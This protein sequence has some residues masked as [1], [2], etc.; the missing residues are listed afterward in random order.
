MSFFR[1]NSFYI[2]P[3]G[4]TV[5]HSSNS[6]QLILWMQIFYIFFNSRFI[7]FLFCFLIASFPTDNP[8]NIRSGHLKD[9]ISNNRTV[10]QENDDILFL[11]QCQ[12]ITKSVIRCVETSISV[13]L[14]DIIL[15]VCNVKEYV[16]LKLIDW[17]VLMSFLPKI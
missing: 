9:T 12:S 1:C 11:F 7:R 17:N 10:I 5:F 16:E 3:L 2:V 14:L 13:S 6:L 4:I 8:I 15:S